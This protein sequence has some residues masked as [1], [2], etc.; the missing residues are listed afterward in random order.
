[1]D[2]LDETGE[3]GAGTEEEGPGLPP[4]VLALFEELGLPP[5]CIPGFQAALVEIAGGLAEAPEEVPDLV[6]GLLTGLQAALENQDPAAGEAALLELLGETGLAQLDAVFAACLPEEEEEPP[7]E[8]EPKPTPPAAGP[9]HQ[10]PAAA[11]EHAPKPVAYLGYAPTGAA[12]AEAADAT[13]P[14]SAFAGGLV[15]LAGAGAAGYGMRRRAVAS[16]D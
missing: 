13:V 9:S 7:A 8:A 14:M 15:L 10:P 5:E 11:P 12:T 2:A 1:M 3:E 16:R 6:T 4:E